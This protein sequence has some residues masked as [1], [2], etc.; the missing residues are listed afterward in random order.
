[1]Q[2]PLERALQPSP[3]ET[4]YDRAARRLEERRPPWRVRYGVTG[5]VATCDGQ[6]PIRGTCIQAV[7]AQITARRPQ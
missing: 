1:M 5:Y 4:I 7:E 2:T 6:E 3:V